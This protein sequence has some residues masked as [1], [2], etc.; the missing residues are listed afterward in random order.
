VE[1]GEKVCQ[2]HVRNCLEV[3]DEIVKFLPEGDDAQQN[4]VRDLRLALVLHDLGKA[5]SG[6]QAVLRAEQPTWD[7]LRHEV[8][9]TF[10]ASSIPEISPSVLM[11]VLTH[12]R[13][14]P[15]DALVGTVGTC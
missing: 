8:L 7:G 14:L 3:A 13:T 1:H 6:F 10:L 5:A 9:S 2:K 15:S 12:H 11:A 4:L